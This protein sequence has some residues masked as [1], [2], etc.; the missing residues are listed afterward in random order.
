MSYLFLLQGFL[1]TFSGLGMMVGPPLGGAL[2]EVSYSMVY[3]YDGWTF[4]KISGFPF[5]YQCLDTKP[6]CIIHYVIY[7]YFYISSLF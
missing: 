3:I 5:S 1:E 6:T 2:Y 7:G 4:V